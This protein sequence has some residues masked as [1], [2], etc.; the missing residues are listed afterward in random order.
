M[1]RALAED[2]VRHQYVKVHE[3]MRG[4]TPIG[5][6]ADPFLDTLAYSIS[7]QSLEDRT[8]RL[9]KLVRAALIYLALAMH[10]EEQRRRETR[11][12][13]LLMSMPLD[14]WRHSWKR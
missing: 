11:G 10:R 4:P 9:L 7:R 14:R 12:D 1:S 8:L 3:M 2:Y 13:G 5:D 6:R